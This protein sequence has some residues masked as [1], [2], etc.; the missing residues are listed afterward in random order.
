MKRCTKCHS[1]AYCNRQCALADWD[2][3]KKV[4]RTIQNQPQ[5]QD[6]F[7][8]QEHG[9]GW[10][11]TNHEEEGSRGDGSSSISGSGKGVRFADYVSLTSP[12]R[13]EVIDTQR[14]I[15]LCVNR[16]A[17]TTVDDPAAHFSHGA[18]AETAKLLY[19]TIT[20]GGTDVANEILLHLENS[21]PP[22]RE[23]TVAV[24]FNSLGDDPIFE[25]KD[26]QLFA[27][28]YN[29]KV[30]YRVLGTNLQDDGNNATAEKS[31]SIQACLSYVELLSSV[32]E[33]GIER[34]PNGEEIQMPNQMPD[35][36]QEGF[37]NFLNNIIPGANNVAGGGG[38]NF[39]VPP[40]MFNNENNNGN[41]PPGEADAAGDG[42]DNNGAG[43]AADANNGNNNQMPAGLANFLNY[44]MNEAGVGVGNANNDNANGDN[45]NGGEEAN[46]DEDLPPA[47]E[48]VADAPPADNAN[49]G[50]QRQQLPQGGPNGP[51]GF[52]FNF[53]NGGGAHVHVAHVNAPDNLPPGMPQMPPPGAFF[54]S[55]YLN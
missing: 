35:D 10:R 52:Q 20:Q 27:N 50:Q 42:N 5:Q 25:P 15:R 4:C 49:A 46:I 1:V 8:L 40:G 23:I 33:T 17:A 16:I 2:Y 9:F 44:A 37:M 31:S 47:V 13:N 24:G 53:P 30:T 36:V 6:I 41:P 7:G 43:A 29:C 48:D 39:F 18:N 14:M 3:H 22:D 38:Q 26:V 54:Q 11:N 34:A 55:E 19:D 32:M 51:G 45:D 12:Q 28:I 21:P